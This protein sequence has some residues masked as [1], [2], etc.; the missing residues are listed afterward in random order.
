MNLK[1]CIK[2]IGFRIWISILCDFHL[3]SEIVKRLWA[4]LKEKNLQDPENKQWFTP[5][6]LMEPVFGSERI[7]AR[8]QRLQNVMGSLE[9]RCRYKKILRHFY[10]ISFQY[11]D[12][13]LAH[14]MT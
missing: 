7:K 5:D 3:R 1:I 6:K 14:Y 9:Y 13:L 12:P 10:K 4:Y 11:F 2:C 8:V